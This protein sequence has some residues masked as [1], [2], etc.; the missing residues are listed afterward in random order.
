MLPFDQK[1]LLFDLETE[2]LNLAYSRPWELSYVLGQGNKVIGKR[3]IYIDIPDLDLPFFIKKLCGFDQKKYDREKISPQ[4]AWD[5]FK[6][7]LYN[8]EYKVLGQNILK[9]DANILGVLSEMCGEKIDYS[10]IDRILDT[11][12]LAVAHKEGLEKPR[13]NS[14][15]TE[16]QYKILN[17]R[18]LKAKASQKVLLKHFGI[19]HDP[20]LLHDGLYDCEMSWEIFKQLKK[21]LEL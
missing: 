19:K 16:W 20:N 7:Y 21:A 2:G 8:P 17:D 15:M 1:Y 11:R 9:Y 4:E 10:F 18:S 3:Q 12:P 14:S 13:G 6:E 5:H